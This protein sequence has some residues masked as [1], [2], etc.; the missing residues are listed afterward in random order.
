MTP[1]PRQILVVCYGNICRSP[2]AEA[3]L[4][5]ELAQRG[6]DGAYSVG[7]AGVGA[8]DG[9]PAAPF[10][11]SVAAAHGLDLS[12][13]QARRLTAAMAAGA[14][15]VIAM[16]EF[17][18]DLILRIA[19]DI[20]VTAWQ[21]DDPYGGPEAGYRAAFAVIRGLV[22]SFVAGLDGPLPPAPDGLRA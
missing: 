4:R 22:A 10:T 2:M 14:D 6:L 11:R 1:T 19:G 17:V 8:V 15:V 9:E 5:L 3:L 12:T 13:H 16:D 7:S 18:E 20:P 21:V